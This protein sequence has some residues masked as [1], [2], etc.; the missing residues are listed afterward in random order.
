M[1]EAN[2][3]ED[4]VLDDWANK[5]KTK[6]ILE[7][8]IIKGEIPEDNWPPACV[9]KFKDEF[10]KTHYKHQSVSGLRRL[11]NEI[12]M[13]KVRVNFDRQTIDH[14]RLLYPTATITQQGFP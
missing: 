9:D 6:A 11:W 12:K 7:S 1:Y 13:R 10:K 4:V 3:G 8:M 5:S 14:D 2:N